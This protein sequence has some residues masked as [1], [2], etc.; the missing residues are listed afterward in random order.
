MVTTAQAIFDNAPLGARIRYSD[1]TPRPPERFK[2]KVREWEARNGSGRLTQRSPAGTGSHPYP[3]TFTLHEADY[4]SE[5]VIVLSVNK[6]FAVTDARNFEIVDVP[7][8][9]AALVVQEWND[10]RELLHVAAD[11]AAAES[12]RNRHG[13]S[14]AQVEIVGETD[15]STQAA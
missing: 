8:P 2:R 9:G 3:A 14:R 6:M 4:G 7:P 11:R 5:D 10:Q 15:S 1:S 13:Y 12:W